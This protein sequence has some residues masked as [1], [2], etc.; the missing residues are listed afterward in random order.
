MDRQTQQAFDAVFVRMETHAKIH[1]DGLADIAKQVGEQAV[2]IAH[3]EER[4][5][6]F[7][8][9]FDDF[10]ENVCQER[11]KKTDA[12]DID[13]DKL[14]NTIGKITLKAMFAVGLTAGTAM[15]LVL[16]G[17]DLV[18]AVVGLVKP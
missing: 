6:A 1:A 10:V 4:T 18:K 11:R 7:R 9:R 15:G 17:A 5:Q 14:K 3:Q 8:E 2:A 12:I 13:M 16:K